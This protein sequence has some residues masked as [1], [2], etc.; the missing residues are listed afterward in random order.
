MLHAN[1]TNEAIARSTAKSRHWSRSAPRGRRRRV[2]RHVGHP[3]ASAPPARP[4]IQGGGRAA[5]RVLRDVVHARSPVRLAGRLQC[6]VR[7]L[8]RP[9]EPAAAPHDRCPSNRS[10]RRGSRCDVGAAAAGAPNLGG[11]TTSAWD[12][13]TTCASRRTTTR[14]TRQRSAG[15][16]PS[17]R[18]SG[19]S[20]C[21]SAGASWPITPACGRVA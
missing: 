10:H 18:T 21:D 1:Q 11:S 14:L 4:R 9:R 3:D 20:G 7:R 16:S 17:L 13:T 8:A 19:V 6:P 15:S 2:L 12:A 5:Q